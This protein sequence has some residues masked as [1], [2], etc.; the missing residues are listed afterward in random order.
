[1][2]VGRLVGG[3]ESVRSGR[4]SCAVVAVTMND[5]CWSWQWERGAGEGT[6]LNS[7]IRWS[8]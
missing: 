5:F 8:F 2:P 3:E 6:P 4:G 7:T 1:M